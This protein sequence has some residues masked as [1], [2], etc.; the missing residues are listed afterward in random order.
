VNREQRQEAIFGAFD[1]VVSILGFMFGMAVHKSPEA[2]MAIG[3]L[4]GSVS[5]GIS[6]GVGEI[7]KGD[8]SWRARL[9]VGL[10][11]FIATLI[12]SLVPVWPFFFFPMRLAGIIGG[13]GS[14]LVA[15][16][17]GYA[18]R[19]GWKGYVTAYAT[20]A[21]AAGLTLAIVSVI[22]QSAA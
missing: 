10:A 5:A 8:E 2:A 3:G 4:G 13:V 22:P 16:W 6:M 14:L 17:I 1:G 9:P 12:G 19:A 21:L 11:M 20:L 7:E 18:K 15:T